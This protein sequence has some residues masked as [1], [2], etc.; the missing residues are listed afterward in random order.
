MPANN[1]AQSFIK[2]NQNS[3]NP[4]MP[5]NSILAHGCSKNQQI[6]NYE[7]IDENTHKIPKHLVHKD[8]NSNFQSLNEEQVV[9]SS[10]DNRTLEKTLISDGGT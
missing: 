2:H 7:I 3:T 6:E 4:M 5:V 8:H 10:E 9:F 1:Q